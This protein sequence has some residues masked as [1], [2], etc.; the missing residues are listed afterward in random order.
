MYLT[1]FL[2]VALFLTLQFLGKVYYKYYSE[3]VFL[4]YTLWLGVFI[5]EFSHFLACKLTFAKVFEFK[6]GLREGHVKHSKSKIPI[7]GG[8]LISLAPFLAGIV[9]LVLLFLWITGL[10]WKEFIELT[11]T[12]RECLL[13]IC[14]FD[15]LFTIISQKVDFWSWKFAI[16]AVLNFILLAVFNPS[17]QDFKNVFWGMGLYVI[18]SL[19]IPALLPLNVLL[20]YVEVW[21]VALLL[22]ATLLLFAYFTLKQ[23]LLRR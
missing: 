3:I 22:G 12:G 10:G 2:V 11:G 8:L 7:I 18:A 5:H 9:L 1:T 19:F 13:G 17:R 6:V 15:I 14:D 21:A 16:Y 23:S 20:L 4:R